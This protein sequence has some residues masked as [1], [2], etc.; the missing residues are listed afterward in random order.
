M[1]IDRRGFIN[2]VGVAS[3]AVLINPFKSFANPM[4]TISAAGYELVV[5]G[6]NWGF[7]GTIQE[8]CAR[9]KADGFDGAE[10]WYPAD[11][12]GQQEL[13][14]EFKKN[15]LRFGIL[16]GSGDA[17]PKTN[18]DHFAQMLE[19]AIKAKPLYINCH[20]GKDY[21]SFADNKSFMDLTTIMSKE[22]GIPVYHET[23]RGKSLYSAPI[24]KGF[25]NSLPELRVT[26]DISHWCNVHESM[27]DDQK[28][29][30]ALALSRT[31]HIHARIGHP[32]GP[33]VS[34]PRAPEWKFAADAHFGWWDRVVEQKKKEGRRMTILTEF[35]PPDYMPTTAYTRQPLADQWQ[36]N[37][38]MLEVLRKRYS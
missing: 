25:I 6:T 16:I 20:S 24:T 4:E 23:H 35:G 37:K 12:K 8:F 28:E 5:L 22:S 36:I 17:N 1:S 7:S 15:G 27:L 34:D 14:E 21:F 19:R 33:Q 3:A 26:L 31:D 29:T 38:Y 9:I 30:I 18:L 11:E 13:Q 32:E 10:I 2:Q